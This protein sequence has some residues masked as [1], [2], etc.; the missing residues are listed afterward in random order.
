MLHWVLYFQ[1]YLRRTPLVYISEALDYGML[2][3]F[4][5]KDFLLRNITMTGNDCLSMI[6]SLSGYSGLRTI[7]CTRGPRG[8]H[9]G[10]CLNAGSTHIIKLAYLVAQK[11][12]SQLR[13]QQPCL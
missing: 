7:Y 4:E 9:S 12:Y 2:L 10:N 13:S 6:R 3:C 11:E 5:I 8:D 1:F